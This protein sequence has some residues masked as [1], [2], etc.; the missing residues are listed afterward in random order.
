MH[1]LCQNMVF[2]REFKNFDNLLKFLCF[3]SV[4]AF[5]IQNYRMFI[6][7]G[8]DKGWAWSR[9]TAD[10]NDA[11]VSIVFKECSIGSVD[12]SFTRHLYFKMFLYM[13]LWFK[14]TF[15]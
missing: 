8:T 9:Y 1:G 15:K 7:D 13:W 12:W 11:R 6:Q 5:S 4:L 14:H 10:E 2:R 3:L